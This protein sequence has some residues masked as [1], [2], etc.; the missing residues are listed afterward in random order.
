MPSQEQEQE[1]E[2]LEVLFNLKRGAVCSFKSKLTSRWEVLIV[3][4]ST[5][6]AD[7]DSTSS[8][9]AAAAS[10]KTYIWN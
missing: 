7:D 5:Y 2:L 4:T 6:A 8:L 1:L 3:G 9:A 10:K